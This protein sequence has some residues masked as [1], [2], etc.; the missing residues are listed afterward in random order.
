VPI[1]TDYSDLYDAL[2]FFSGTP[3]GLPGHDDLAQK[4]GAQAHTFTAEQWR[5]EDMQVYVGLQDFIRSPKSH[6]Q[7][8]T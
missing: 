5:P 7:C 8:F 4:I 3:D 2:A 1:Q 6:H